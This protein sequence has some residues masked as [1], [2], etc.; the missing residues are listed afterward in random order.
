ME[1]KGGACF[2]TLL[3]RGYFDKKY[4][5]SQDIQERTN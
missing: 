5:Q 3:N 2:N 4:C 1:I